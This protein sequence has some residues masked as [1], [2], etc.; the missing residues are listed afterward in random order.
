MSW[1]FFSG[2]GRFFTNIWN[3]LIVGVAKFALDVVRFF[4]D[5]P[6]N[7]QKVFTGAGNWLVNVGRNIIQ[8]PLDGA[9]SLLKNI[10]SFFLDILPD[11]I[12][13]PFQA[14]LGIASPS[15]VVAGYGRY[16]MEGYIAG[17]DAMHS[18]VQNA[19]LDTSAFTPCRPRRIRTA[20]DDDSSRCQQ[21]ERTR[22]PRGIPDRCS[23]R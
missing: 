17:L 7:I 10:G 16:T 21:Q 14:A 15:K 19:I 20:H 3:G 23:R 8:G 13:T 12:K 22:S 1:G 11:W 4:Q 6:G 2:I 18:K 5:I 9:T